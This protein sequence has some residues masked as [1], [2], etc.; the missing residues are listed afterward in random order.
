MGQ[1]GGPPV[2]DLTLL[3]LVPLALLL[4][5]FLG[6]PSRFHPLVGFGTMANWIESRLNHAVDDKVLFR[7]GVVAWIIV[8][9]PIAWIV[10]V[11]DHQIEGVWMGALCGWLAIGWHS[12][13][14][15]GRAVAQALANNE[16][17]N[18]RLR[19]AYLV[20]RDTTELDGS[21]LSRATI[22][23]LLEN[24]S[25]AI[26]APLFWLMMLGAPGVVMYRL[27]N[28]LDAMWGYRNERFEY[29]GKF[30]ALV[31]D[32]LNYIPARM[33]AFLYMFSGN[34]QQAWRAWVTQGSRWYSPN[35][36]VVMASGAGALTLKLGGN[37]VYF[38]IEKQRP[39]LGGENRP[40]PG[41]IYRALRLI[42]R[43]VYGLTGF[44]LSCFFI[45][46]IMG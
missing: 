20:S 28:T 35:A 26:I 1:G 34:S 22:E 29:F 12:L 13:V 7:R 2:I 24:G 27:S 16:L 37:A 23:S 5:R 18:A 4:D 14:D 11:I 30:T 40:E 6:E 38:G 31:D 10:Y 32:V 15:H 42:N 41:D 25:D 39:V 43:S 45:N 9:M 3:I 17:D 44:I 8:V 46:W 33:T 21:A 36:G 19:T